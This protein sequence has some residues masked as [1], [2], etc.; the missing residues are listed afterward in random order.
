MYYILFEWIVVS[1][2]ILRERKLDVSEL[3]SITDGSNQVGYERFRL[4][5]KILKWAF[6][7]VFIS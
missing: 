3:L 1:I 6:H 4:K 2:I 7:V 5:E